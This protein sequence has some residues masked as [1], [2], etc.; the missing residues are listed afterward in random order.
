M[1]KF[2]VRS[3]RFLAATAI[4]TAFSFSAQA[5]VISTSGT[6][7]DAP[8][9]AY[10]LF[11]FD[12]TGPG[13]TTLFLDGDANGDA[14][15]GVFSGTDVLSNATFISQDDDSGGDLDSFLELSLAIGS[16]T[17][18]ITTHGSYWDTGS[19]SINTNHDHTPMGYTLT[20][21]GNVAA[22]EVPEPATFALLGLGLAG[23]IA[24]RRRKA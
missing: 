9:G 11:N 3:L 10:A 18:W 22:N 7:P 4:A 1:G 15:L 21:N 17:A 23:L 13:N 24:G 16:Y 8:V 19:N 6:L 5:A 20:I 12:V 14:W 2:T